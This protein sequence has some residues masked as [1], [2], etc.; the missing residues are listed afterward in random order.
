VEIASSEAWGWTVWERLVNDARQAVHALRKT[1]GFTALVVSTL[2]VVL[3]M[4]TAVFSIVNAVMLRSLPYR[5]PDRRVSPWEEALKRQEM[6]A[7]NS[8]GQ[9]LGGAGSRQRTT[10]S[11]ANLVDYRK[12]TNAFQELAGVETARMNLTGNGSPERLTGESV[13]ANYFA[14]LGVLPQIGR[15]FTADEDRP[16]GPAVVM[17]S[18]DFWQRRLGGDT[19]VLN[20]N[21]QLDAP[22]VPGDRSVAA[23]LSGNHRIRTSRPRRVLRPRRILQGLVGEPRRSRD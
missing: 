20:R 6:G 22:C 1:P 15:T 3:G 8:S 4:N 9:D 17:V 2:A 18:H 23:R 21:L 11:P 12:A 5:Q 16:E 7:L 19:A 13:T 10:V 14:A